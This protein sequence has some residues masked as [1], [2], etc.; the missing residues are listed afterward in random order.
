LLYNN[1]YIDETDILRRKIY[2]PL[3][4]NFKWTSNIT[5]LVVPGIKNIDKTGDLL[6]ITK[7]VKDMLVFK[8]CGYR[9]VISTNNETTFIPE[10]L[11]NKLSK[12]YKRIL[13]NFDNDTTG[14]KFGDE[15]AAQYGLK[16]VY[17]PDNEPKDISDYF[18]KYGYEKT[19]KLI[20]TLLCTY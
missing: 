7:S 13:I 12:R 4:E 11:F 18:Q 17:T 8:V 15:F 14:K 3:N 6:I 1:F 20:T 5:S 9:N 19:K 2:C 10:K 16:A